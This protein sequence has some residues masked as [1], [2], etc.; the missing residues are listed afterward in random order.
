MAMVPDQVPG[1]IPNEVGKILQAYAHTVPT[2]Q[3]IVE[4]GAYRG[5]STCFLATGSAEGNSAK[6]LSIDPWGLEGSELMSNVSTTQDDHWSH[7][8]KCGVDHLV[9][10]VRGFSQRMPLPVEPVGL[11][12]IDGAHDYESVSEDIR[13]FCPLVV[14]GGT[15]IFDDYK[16]HCRGV[17]RA[18]N[19]LM[20]DRKSWKSWKTSAGQL[21]IGRKR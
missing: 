2:D 6:V 9:T 8:V 7:V 17:D 14:S 1:R 4:I 12:W 21:A 3:L 20:K 15:V 18:V 13:R 10:Q 5:K 11:L 16:L 19:R